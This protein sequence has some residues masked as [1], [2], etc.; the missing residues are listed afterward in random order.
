MSLSCFVF[1]R[2]LRTEDEVEGL[3]EVEGCK[4]AGNVGR[5]GIETNELSTSTIA[6]LGATG[7]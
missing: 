4:F 3:D 5:K 6:L 7:S 1:F 2:D